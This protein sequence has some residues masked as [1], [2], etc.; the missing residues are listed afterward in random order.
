MFQK[1][2]YPFQSILQWFE[3]ILN[4]VLPKLQ[5]RLLSVLFLPILRLENCD[6]IQF[7]AENSNKNVVK[8][9]AAKLNKEITIRHKK[10]SLGIPFQ[11][12]VCHTRLSNEVLS[13]KNKKKNLFLCCSNYMPL[14]Q[15]Q[16][17]LTFVDES[18]VVLEV[19]ISY[20]NNWTWDK[21]YEK[22]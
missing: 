19:L 17:Y 22:R 14:L 11:F 4:L 9:L 3:P 16:L 21:L 5:K 13:N 6:C 10:N 12:H 8:Q 20:S 1:K 18:I 7:S 2:Q 15:A